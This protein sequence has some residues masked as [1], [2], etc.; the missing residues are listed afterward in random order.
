MIQIQILG[1]MVNLEPDSVDSIVEISDCTSLIWIGTIELAVLENFRD[2][3]KRIEENRG[4]E[5]EIGAK[6][7]IKP[8]PDAPCEGDTI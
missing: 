3:A 6:G 4:Y 2:L 1:G 7:E 8:E 5:V